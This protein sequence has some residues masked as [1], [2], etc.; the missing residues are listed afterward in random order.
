MTKWVIEEIREEFKKFLQCKQKHNQPETVGHSK[1]HA[2]RNK[3]RN[4]AP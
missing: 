2:K 4:D 1:G 3:Q